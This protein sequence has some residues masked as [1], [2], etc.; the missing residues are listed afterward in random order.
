MNAIQDLDDP[1]TE[2]FRKLVAKDIELYQREMEELR[3]EDIL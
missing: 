2:L 1:E 3:W